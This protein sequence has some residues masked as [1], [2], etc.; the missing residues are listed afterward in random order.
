MGKLKGSF[1]VFLCSVWCLQ[2]HVVVCYLQAESL[3]CRV[4]E[5]YDN[6]IMKELEKNDC[7]AADVLYL[8]LITMAT[9]P[10]IHTWYYKVVHYAT[11]WQFKPF[12]RK[13][14]F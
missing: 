5:I 12:G 9:A 8:L 3:L 4:L 7:G 10:I 13:P 14:L 2:R 6:N 1:S 11:T